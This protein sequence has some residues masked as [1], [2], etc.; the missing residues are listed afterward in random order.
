MARAKREEI[1]EFLCDLH[2]AIDGKSEVRLIIPDRKKNE[3]LFLELGMTKRAAKE[4][5][6]RLSVE[7]YS[8]GPVS[9]EKIKGVCV[10]IFGMTLGEIEIYIKFRDLRQKKKLLLCLSYHKAQWPL[11]LPYKE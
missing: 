5:L 8:S 9:D 7:N 11:E 10:W 2:E 6:R 3:E 4:E 1:A